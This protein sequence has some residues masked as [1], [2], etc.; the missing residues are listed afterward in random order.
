MDDLD[1]MTK[2]IKNVYD[3]PLHIQYDYF[4]VKSSGF[5]E[6]KPTVNLLENLDKHTKFIHVY[7]PS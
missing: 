7:K 5:N 6:M 4:N 2:P 1:N 3:F